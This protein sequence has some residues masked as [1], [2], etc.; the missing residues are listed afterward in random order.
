MIKTRKQKI[1]K[2]NYERLFLN[3][4]KE[5]IKQ[6]ESK[7]IDDDTLA[8]EMGLTVKELKDYLTLKKANFGVYHEALKIIDNY[9]TSK[10]LK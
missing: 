5:I 7:K 10:T 2:Y 4:I 8:S 6:Q 3:M 9:D 1:I